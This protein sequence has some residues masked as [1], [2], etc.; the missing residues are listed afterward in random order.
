MRSHRSSRR[1]ALAE[2]IVRQ[3]VTFGRVLREAGLEVGPGRICDAMTGLDTIDLSRRD[4][5]YWTLRQTLVSRADDID[6]F[7]RAFAAWFL[8]A[9]ELA[10]PRSPQVE[11]LK[12]AR[13][14]SRNGTEEAEASSE[15][16][17]RASGWSAQ[18]LLRQKDFS[19]LAPEEL[20]RIRSMIAELAQARPQRRSRRLRRHPQ[21]STLDLRRLV[22]ASLATGGDPVDR[23]FRRRVETNRKLIVLCDVSGSMEPYS[24]AI[25]L[26]VHALLESGRGVEAFAFGTRL[27]RLT[28]ELAG[29]DPERAL[30][31]ASK[32]VVD[33]SG[34][35][36]I[37]ASLKAFNDRW[38]RRALSRGAVVVI[39]SDG[40]E[41][42][43]THTVAREMAR[44]ARSAYSVVWVN[45]L[46][47]HPD[48][49][50]LAGGMRAALPYVD[51]FLP[52]HNLES[53]EDLAGVLAGIERRHAA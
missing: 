11:R 7:D 36:R 19:E 24:R 39:V 35:T 46:K 9:P 28:E 48:Y 33:W 50:P 49:E 53:L 3:V 10:P 18:E 15:G 44:L 6:A 45:P 4:D 20:A 5:V 26:F 12:T 14:S 23:A 17:E 13:V 1:R 30:D 40:W 42:E 41:R 16:E 27:T 32:R 29:V 21:G 51:R 37:G 22:R 43:D 38:G 25:L 2:P 47:G 31:E 8:R 52:G 34:G